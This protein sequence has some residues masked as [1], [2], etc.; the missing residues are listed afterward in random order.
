M[1][2]SKHFTTMSMVCILNQ[3]LVFTLIQ[4]EYKKENSS[5]P[6]LEYF[7]SFIQDI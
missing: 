2:I 6:Y 1:D 5:L 7:G 4:K 3:Y